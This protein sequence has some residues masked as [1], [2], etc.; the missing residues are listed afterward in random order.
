MWG[1]CLGAESA[2]L[3]EAERKRLED[4]LGEWRKQLAECEAQLT[5]V[6]ESGRNYEK[7]R[8]YWKRRIQ[9]AQAQITQIEAKLKAP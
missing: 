1:G 9:Q 4:E 8:A 7:A 5:G 6:A 3:T 2:S